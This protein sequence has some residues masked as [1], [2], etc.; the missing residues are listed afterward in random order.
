MVQKKKAYEL[1]RTFTDGGS[2]H[3]E[4]KTAGETF[5]LQ[6]YR[7]TKFNSLNDYRPVAYKRAIGRLPLTS[8]FNLATLPST[9]AAAN[10]HSYRT[11]HTF[12]QWMGNYLEP[13]EWGWQTQD[14]QLYP[15]E[16]DIAAAPDSLLN[17][18]SCGCK[19]D[20]CNTHGCSCK[21]TWTF[22]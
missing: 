3:D 8:I 1:F 2:T 21:K 15:V 18:V 11:F 19:P 14:G 10:Q 13:I 22:L 6:I 17:M 20:G 7:A 16:T 5:F 4:V 12:Q 9:S